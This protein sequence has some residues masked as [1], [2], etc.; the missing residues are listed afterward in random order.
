MK[1]HT[2][3]QKPGPSDF[4]QEDFKGF[5]FISLCKTERPRD[6][7]I[8][9]PRG[10]QSWQKSNRRFRVNNIKCISLL[11]LGLKFK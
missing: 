7:V 6:S 11:A 2:K 9:G 4:R 10:Q 3:Y 5:N 8:S 1:L